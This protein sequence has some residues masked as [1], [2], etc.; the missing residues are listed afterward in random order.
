MRSQGGGLRVNRAREMKKESNCAIYILL[1]MRVRSNT[2]SNM[3]LLTSQSKNARAPPI[4]S[5]GS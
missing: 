3:V 5:I 4:E 2:E 1:V